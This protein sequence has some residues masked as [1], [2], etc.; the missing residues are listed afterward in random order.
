MHT[1]ILYVCR[2]HVANTGSLLVSYDANAFEVGPCS[3]EI[4]AKKIEPV[5]WTIVAPQ[6]VSC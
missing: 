3:T 5:Y 4:P 1:Y 6:L 2:W